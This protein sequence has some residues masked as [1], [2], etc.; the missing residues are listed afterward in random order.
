[1]AET[2]KYALAGSFT[3]TYTVKPPTLIPVHVVFPQLLFMSSGPKKSPIQTMYYYVGCT[4]P[5]TIIFLHQSFR[6]PGPDAQYS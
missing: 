5:Q 1:M 4:A 2:E 6:I 3:Y